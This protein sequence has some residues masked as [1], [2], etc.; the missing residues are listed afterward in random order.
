MRNKTIVFTVALVLGL[1]GISGIAFTQANAIAVQPQTEKVLV[2]N[3]GSSYAYHRY[4]CSGL[5]RC[6]HAVTEISVATAKKQGR[7]PCKICYK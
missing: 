4:T 7:T 6:T 2:C 3:S 1:V 5:K